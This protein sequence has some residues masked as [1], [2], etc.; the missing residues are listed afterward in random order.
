MLQ[1]FDHHRPTEIGV[2]N[3]AVVRAGEMTG[4]A[5]PVNAVLILLVKAREHL[6]QLVRQE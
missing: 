4:V 3:G 6:K 5:T 1:D 2:I